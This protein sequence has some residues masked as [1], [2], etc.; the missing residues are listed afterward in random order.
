MNSRGAHVHSSNAS[1]VPIGIGSVRSMWIRQAARS[2]QGP[3]QKA[4]THYIARCSAFSTGIVWWRRGGSNSR[5]SH[6]ERDALPAELRPHRLR[7]L[8]GR[9]EHGKRKPVDSARVN[10]WKDRFLI[11][12]GVLPRRNIL[13][14][15]RFQH[16][17]RY[18][19][20]SL[21]RYA[22]QLQDHSRSRAA[23]PQRAFRDD[24]ARSRRQAADARLQ[25]RQRQLRR[26][27]GVPQH[28]GARTG[29]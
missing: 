1:A 5:P 29:R 11:N 25:Y 6:C 24:R 19:R 4:K 13:G 23:F 27:P 28:Q 10:G 16:R 15:G 12:C 26:A 17:A 3:G 21:E 22:V 18:Q 20:P 9:F 7:I 2:G 14:H 8:A